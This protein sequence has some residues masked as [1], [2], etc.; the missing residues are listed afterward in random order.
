MGYR[1][2]TNQSFTIQSDLITL[3]CLCQAEYMCVCVCVCVCVRACVC[4]AYIYDWEQRRGGKISDTQ[5]NIL[6]RKNY[7]GTGRSLTSQ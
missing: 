2:L 3:L 1:R 6:P 5:L 4:V 7:N